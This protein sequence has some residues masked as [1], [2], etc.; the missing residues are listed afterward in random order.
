M[1]DKQKQVQ[2]KIEAKWTKAQ[3]KSQIKAEDNVLKY[4]SSK[5]YTKAFWQWIMVDSTWKS[6]TGITK[7]W[8][9]V[10]VQSFSRLKS[11]CL[12]LTI[13]LRSES[14]ILEGHEYL[15]RALHYKLFS[16]SLS[17]HISFL[18]I[19]LGLE[20]A[21]FTVPSWVEDTGSTFSTLVM[22]SWNFIALSSFLISKSTEIAQVYVF[23]VNTPNGNTFSHQN[24]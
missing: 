5:Q 12:N 6:N 10:A 11:I 3:L 16:I 4:S 22:T 20:V 24:S 15:K 9:T 17:H 14:W 2:I 7:H 13:M 8:A 23:T 21:A 19:H 1:N 18:T